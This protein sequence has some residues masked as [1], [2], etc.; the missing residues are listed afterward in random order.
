MLVYI[1]VFDTVKMKDFQIQQGGGGEPKLDICICVYLLRPQGSQV[2]FT[3]Y[4]VGILKSCRTLTGSAAIS[5][6]ATAT[7]MYFPANAVLHPPPG[8]GKT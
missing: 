1:P 6:H 2:Y 5:T 7:T 8:S 3:L 4:L